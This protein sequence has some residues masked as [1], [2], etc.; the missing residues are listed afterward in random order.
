VL[1]QGLGSWIH[2]RRI[3]S[4]GKV[5]IISQGAELTYDDFDRNINALAHAFADFGITKGDRVAYLGENH[6]AFLEVFFAATQIGAIFVP[7]NTRLA[8]PE[9]HYALEDS[10]SRILVHAQALSDLASRSAVGFDDLKLV[11]ADGAGSATSVALDA[12]RSTNTDFIDAEVAEE[13]PAI[14][15]YTSGTTGHPKGA[16]LLHRN[17]TWNTFNALVDYDVTSSEINLLIGPMF[18]V[19]ALGMGAFPV[20]LKG[21]TLILETAFDPVQILH[22]IETHRVTMMSGVPTTFQLLCEHP[23]F[24]STDLSSIRTFTCG[25]SAMPMRVLD[26]YEDRGLSFTGGYGMTETSPGATSLSPRYSRSKVGSAGTSHFFTDVR[27]VREDGD[28]AETGEI[29]EIVIRGKNVID[30]YWNRPEASKDSFIDGDWFRSGDMGYL[31]E[32]GFLFIAD[33]LK[34][35]IISGGENIYP[36]EI[37]QMM[38]ELE[39]ISAV[40]L[41]GIPDEKW[42]EVPWAIVTVMPGTTTSLEEVRAHIDGRIARYKMPKNLIIVDEFPRTGSG[43]I[44]KADLRKQFSP[45]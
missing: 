2:R 14:I 39:H 30:E 25:G 19:A 26:A 12:F 22:L 36:A 5:A 27:I 45:S 31:D 41:I 10:G 37:E 44:R 33:R 11:T 3:K 1:N 4:R 21:G 8:A 38:I 29:G 42:G 16:V 18:H 43:K 15:L 24:A 35:M 7:L 20:M 40:A 6:P 34:D 17:M 28:D 13:D 23:N 9:L 32:D